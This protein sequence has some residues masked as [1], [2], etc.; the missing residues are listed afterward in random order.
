MTIV[1]SIPC[2]LNVEC[3]NR[4]SRCRCPNCL[5]PTE[6]RNEQGKKEHICHFPNCGKVYGKTSHLKVKK[7][8]FVLLT[9]YL[10]FSF[11]G[12]HKMAHG[13]ATFRVQLVILRKK[14]HAQWWTSAT[15]SN[16][17]RREKVSMSGK[18][19]NNTWK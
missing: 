18:L 10:H 4:C 13:W 17:H 9:F 5:S 16:T 14:F 3:V 12:A 15:S 6:T 11:I 1:F 8:L 7:I 19:P 2:W